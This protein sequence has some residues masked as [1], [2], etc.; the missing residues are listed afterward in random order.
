MS[1]VFKENNKSGGAT[2]RIQEF[3]SRDCAIEWEDQGLA[4]SLYSTEQPATASSPL[5]KCCAC[6]QW[7]EPLSFDE[8]RYVV[9]VRIVGQLHRSRDGGDSEGLARQ[10]KEEVAAACAHMRQDRP[11]ASAQTWRVT[12]CHLSG[13]AEFEE[14]IREMEAIELR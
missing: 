7:I 9:N 8:D 5:A 10:I 1:I 12:D 14:Q 4:F 3:C 13:T 6:L 11:A 2:G